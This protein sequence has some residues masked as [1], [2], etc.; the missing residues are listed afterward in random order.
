MAALLV[1]DSQ[2]AASLTPFGSMWQDAATGSAELGKNMSEFVSQSPI[3]FSGM[4]K[5]LRV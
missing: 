3:D 1:G 2:I 4:F 5:Q